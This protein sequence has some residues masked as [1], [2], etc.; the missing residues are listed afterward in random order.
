MQNTNRTQHMKLLLSGKH[1]HYN[2][3]ICIL[4]TIY[5]YDVKKHDKIVHQKGNKSNLD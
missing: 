5:L 4:Q 1:E 2:C 3:K